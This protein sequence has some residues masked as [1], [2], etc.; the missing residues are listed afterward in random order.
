VTTIAYT[1]REEGHASLV[2][3]DV[4]GRRVAVLADGV[5]AAGAHTIAFDAIRLPSGPYIV[6]METSAYRRNQMM[7]L[8]K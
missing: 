1:P 6:R 8:A 2:V 5:Q 7:M 4:L 3:Y